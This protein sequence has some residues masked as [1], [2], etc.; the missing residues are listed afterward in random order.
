MT[1][2]TERELARSARVLSRRDP[3]LARVI[4]RFGPPPL[5]AREPG[6][7]TLVQI[8]LEQQVSLASARAALARLALAAG[9]VTPERLAAASDATFVSA[10]LTR[11]KRAYIRAL[12]RAVADG[13][14]D[15]GRVGAMADAEAHRELVTLKG[16]GAWSADIYLLMALGRPD[17]W[18]SHDLALAGAMREVKRLRSLPKPERQLEIAERWRPWRAVAARILWHHYLS[19]PSGRVT[20]SRA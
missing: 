3:D 18:P 12:A 10:G 14:F 6:F 8:I 7:A 11:Q 19:R 5:W 15:I 1:Q 20:A 4:A 13:A 17:V 2:L 16:I 9:G